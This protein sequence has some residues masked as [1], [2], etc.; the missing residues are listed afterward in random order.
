MRKKCK[1]A[2]TLIELLIVLMII[3]ILTS[4][5]LPNLF[6]LVEYSRSVEAL[7]SMGMI[8]QSMERCYLMSSASYNSCDNFGKLDL[9]DPTTSTGS[10]FTYTIFVV[11]DTKSYSIRA[12]RN[13]RDNGHIGD[14]VIMTQLPTREIKLSGTGAFSNL[15]N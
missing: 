6:S 12:V 5:A 3:G 9:K 10:H 14:M 1:K 2:F 4:I 11:R 7:N 15:A 8:R 13:S